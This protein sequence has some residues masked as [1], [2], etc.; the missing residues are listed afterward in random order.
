MIFGCI[1]AQVKY[2]KT[3]TF[4]ANGNPKWIPVETDNE[5]V[6]LDFEDQNV[7]ELHKN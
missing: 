4:G 1:T 6:F 5:Q 3:G 2:N 7:I